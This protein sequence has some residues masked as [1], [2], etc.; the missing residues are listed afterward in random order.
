MTLTRSMDDHQYT[1]AGYEPQESTGYVRQSTVNNISTTWA[2]ARP[3]NAPMPKYNPPA[4]I[5]RSQDGIDTFNFTP[6]RPRVQMDPSDS[7]TWQR[8]YRFE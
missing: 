3:V 4:Q 8:Q 7:G 6:L 5:E 1:P 2:I